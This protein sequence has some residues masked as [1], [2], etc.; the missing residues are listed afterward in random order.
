MTKPWLQAA[1]LRTLPLAASGIISGAALAWYHDAFSWRISVLAL[2]T[3][4]LLQILSNFANDYGDFVKGTDNDDRV[5]PQ[6]TLQS[7]ALSAQQMRGAM[8]VMSL[9]SLIS[10]SWL[11]YLATA[12]LGGM[13]WVF[14]AVLGLMAIAAAIMYTVGKRAY[15]YYGM[16]DVM[17]FIFFGLASVV[18]T[19]Y[20][21]AARID[22]YAVLLGIGIGALSTG[23]LNLNNMRDID[24]D[25]ASGKKT[26]ASRLGFAKAKVYH[27]ILIYAGIVVFLGLAF[28]L[29]YEMWA[30]F[31]LILPASMLNKD[32]I[33]IRKT[34]E[35]KDLD[36]FLKKLSLGTFLFS[37][38]F[39]VALIISK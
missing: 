4:L 37:I 24:N 20:L 28:P 30:Y 36:P 16:G 3:A 15:G 2:L 10:G 6:R 34:K 1:R 21:N 17:V 9:L 38:I 7:G 14:F 5:G 12:T 13:A 39:I 19:Y 22:F 11:I 33:K 26:V 8:V 25:I 23:V 27:S 29:K 35:N 32:L 31:I 18:G